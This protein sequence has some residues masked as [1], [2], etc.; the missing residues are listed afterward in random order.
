MQRWQTNSRQGAGRGE[1]VMGLVLVFTNIVIGPISSVIIALATYKAI[2]C[3]KQRCQCR[4]HEDDLLTS[5]L[6][7]K[8]RCYQRV[9]F[10]LVERQ[11]NRSKTGDREKLQHIVEM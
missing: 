10:E 7:F 6:S 2:A 4:E 9:G 8:L 5:S 3:T 11:I 1:E